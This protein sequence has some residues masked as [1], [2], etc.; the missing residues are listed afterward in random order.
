MCANDVEKVLPAIFGKEALYIPYIDPGYV[1]FKEV[2]KQIKLYRE[3][4]GFDPKVIL[5]QN[6][7]IFVSSD[8]EEEVRKIYDEILMSIDRKESFAFAESGGA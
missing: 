1:L 3:A 6:H 2:E 8:S 5:L 4:H 7:G